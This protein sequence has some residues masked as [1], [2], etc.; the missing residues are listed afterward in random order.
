MEFWNLQILYL[1][2][3]EKNKNKRQEASVG[4]LK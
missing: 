1:K 3:V 2:V 4:N